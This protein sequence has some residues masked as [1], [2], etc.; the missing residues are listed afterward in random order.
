MFFIYSEGH[1][2]RLEGENSN[3]VCLLPNPLAVS[4]HHEFLSRPTHFS[5]KNEKRK[6]T[7]EINIVH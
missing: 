6:L 5:Q 1:R 2:Q 3:R 7:K 4:G